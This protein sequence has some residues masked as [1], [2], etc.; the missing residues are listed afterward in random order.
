MRH[1][2]ATILGECL[3]L[4]KQAIAEIE[5]A[6]GAMDTADADVGRIGIYDSRAIAVAFVG[7]E[8]FNEYMA[9]LKAKHDVAEAA[10]DAQRIAELEGEAA[11]LQAQ[12][13]RQGFSTAPV[14]DILEHIKDQLPGIA[15][16][17]GVDRLVSKWDADA[18]SRWE[19]GEQVDVTMLLAAALKPNAKQLKSAQEIQKHPPVPLEEFD[20]DTQERGG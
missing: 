14:D 10:G 15:E 19:R 2:Q 13:H 6:L 3:A 4:E 16:K 5:K 11:A 9:D 8:P 1:A 17:A 12:L 7:S 20:K 18:L